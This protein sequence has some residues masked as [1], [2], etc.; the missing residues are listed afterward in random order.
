MPAKP[1]KMTMNQIA[2]SATR[3]D[4]ARGRKGS[5][6]I[7][8]KKS[9][10]LEFDDYAN[11]RQRQNVQPSSRPIPIG[12]NPQVVPSEYWLNFHVISVAAG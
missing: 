6:A 4:A 5:F 12:P 11:A 3:S 2:I 8:E 1:S 7:F 10:A 9:S